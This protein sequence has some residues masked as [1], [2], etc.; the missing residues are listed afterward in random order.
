MLTD[1]VTGLPLDVWLLKSMSR[2]MPVKSLYLCGS[3]DNLFRIP[4]TPLS[5]RHRCNTSIGNPTYKVI[6]WH[7]LGALLLGFPGSFG[8]VGRRSVKE[9]SGWCPASFHR[10]ASFLHVTRIWSRGVS[11]ELPAIQRTGIEAYPCLPFYLQKNCHRRQKR[12]GERKR[13]QIGRAHV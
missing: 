8:V 5:Q 11:R 2:V 13:K 12:L 10:E 7:D 6:C 4:R 1:Y 3:S 9:V